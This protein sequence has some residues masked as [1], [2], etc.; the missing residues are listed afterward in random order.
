MPD[1]VAVVPDLMPDTV[2]VVPDLIPETVRRVRLSLY[3]VVLIA[4]SAE[5]IRSLSHFGGED[6]PLASLTAS[7]SF[8]RSSF[9]HENMLHGM[10]LLI[11]RAASFSSWYLLLA[12]LASSASLAM[13]SSRRLAS[14]SACVSR[15]A[16]ATL[17]SSEAFSRASFARFSAVSAMS[18]R[19]SSAAS[20]SST[21]LAW[22]ASCLLSRESASCAVWMSSLSSSGASF[23]AALIASLSTLP[24]ASDQDNKYPGIE[25]LIAFA[26][27]ST[28]V[29]LSRAFVATF[30]AASASF[31]LCFCSSSF[32]LA[33]AATEA[34]VASTFFF[35]AAMKRSYAEGD[36]GAD[37]DLFGRLPPGYST[38][39]IC[40]SPT[41][42]KNESLSALRSKTCLLVQQGSRSESASASLDAQR[43]GLSLGRLC[44]HATLLQSV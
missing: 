12:T 29:F 31:A 11:A 40:S 38:R 34:D 2:A 15:S 16:L 8:S 20:V 22:S 26:S 1:T 5:S 43:R 35:I 37:F 28:S 39:G 21:F 6:T 9:C 33:F 4:S 25:D 42:K 14:L 32:C 23:F 7:L 18:I 3:C 24:L 19:F 44:L 30:A 17:A 10:A 36:P 41:P 13:R 27:V